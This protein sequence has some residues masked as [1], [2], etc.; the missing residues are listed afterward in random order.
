MVLL[1]EL[2][3]L[4]VLITVCSEHCVPLC[5]CV[6]FFLCKTG[7]MLINLFRYEERLLI[8][9]AEILSHCLDIVNT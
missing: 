4:R 5:L 2:L 7:I 1:P 6:C 8:L 3:H 9:P